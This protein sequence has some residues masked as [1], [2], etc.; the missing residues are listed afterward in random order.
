MVDFKNWMPRTD[1]ERAAM[2]IAMEQYPNRPLTDPLVQTRYSQSLRNMNKMYPDPNRPFTEVGDLG[3]PPP[4]MRGM[5]G[6]P[7]RGNTQRLPL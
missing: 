6:S 2:E 5:G 4:T 3:N 1:N 7:A